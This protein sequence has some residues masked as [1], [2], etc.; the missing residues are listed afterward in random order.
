MPKFI[1]LTNKKFNRL[2]VLKI[3]GKKNNHYE[4]KCKC[5]CGNIVIVSGGNLSSGHTNSCGCLQK[6]R[7]YNYQIKHGMTHTNT[8]NS[9]SAMIQRCNNINN[10][11]YNNYGG[12]G[13]KVCED[14]YTDFN[15]FLKDMG[16]RPRGMSIDRILVSGNYEKNNCKWSTEKEQQNNKTNNVLLLYKGETKT[17]SEWSDKLSIKYTTLYSRLFEYNWSIEK[18]FST[19][20]RFRSKN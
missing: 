14:W 15:S 3:N 6:E 16:E 11:S 17:I 7:A 1:D 9:W 5:C 4:W 2:T 20:V 10:I 8:Y 12:K 13:I 19:K 18:S